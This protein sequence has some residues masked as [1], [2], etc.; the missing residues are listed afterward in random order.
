MVVL[1]SAADPVVGASTTTGADVVVVDAAVAVGTADAVVAVVVA[2]V[3][4]IAVTAVA[5]SEPLLP[6]IHPERE[7]KFSF[8]LSFFRLF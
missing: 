5:K 7:Y 1:A 4:V 8:F 2:A 6:R 3:A